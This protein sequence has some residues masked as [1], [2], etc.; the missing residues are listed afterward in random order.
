MGLK[1]S[2]TSFTFP[3]QQTAS[4]DL[5]AIICFHSFNWRSSKNCKCPEKIWWERF[6]PTWSIP[7]NSILLWICGMKKG[8]IILLGLKVFI[9]LERNYGISLSISVMMGENWDPKKHH[10]M[11]HKTK[12]LGVMIPCFSHQS[13]CKNQSFFSISSL[14]WLTKLVAHQ[15]SWIGSQA[16][17][18]FIGVFNSKCLCLLTQEA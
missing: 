10:R 13:H 6:I 2:S 7:L 5:R 4:W 18:T 16:L 1:I 12:P 3:Y 9:F 17:L 11:I 15:L 14:F 8:Q